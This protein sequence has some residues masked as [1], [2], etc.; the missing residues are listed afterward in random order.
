MRSEEGSS[1]P[2]EDKP[3]AFSKKEAVPLGP[4]PAVPSLGKHQSPDVA[5]QREP[6]RGAQAAHQASQGRVKTLGAAAEL[7]MEGR[8]LM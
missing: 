2:S 3:V 5:G 6:G 4:Q 1:G 7:W 8:D